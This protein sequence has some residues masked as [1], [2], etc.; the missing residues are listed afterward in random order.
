MEFSIKS[1]APERGRGGCVVVGVF[2]PR[3]LSSAAASA[4]PR[5]QGISHWHPQ[6]AATWT[7]SPAR[8]CCCTTCRASRPSACCWSDLGREREFRDKQIPRSRRGRDP[9]AERDRRRRSRPASDR[10][11]AS[12]ERDTRGRSRRRS[13]W[14]ARRLP[15][16]RNEEQARRRRPRAAPAR[17]H[18]DRA[19]EPNALRGRPAQG[20]A[21][22]HGM[23]LAKDLGNLPPNVCTPTYLAEPGARA[24]EALPHES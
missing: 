20:L 15:F 13:R 16:R 10:A 24:G 7:A 4:R 12:A 5:G 23:S 18:V 21:I 11:R 6:A 17:L 14:R 2:E 22:A 9:R 19:A 1:G 8:P 3:K